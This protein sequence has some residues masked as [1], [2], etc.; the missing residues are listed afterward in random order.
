LAIL[1]T[2]TLGLVWSRG[3]K[4]AFWGGFATAGWAY[5]AA[6]FGPWLNMNGGP[7]LLTTAILDIVYTTVAGT[8]L[9][10]NGTPGAADTLYATLTG[11]TPS[12]NGTPGAAYGLGA[13]FGATPAP[14]PAPHS[15]WTWW[16]SVS[17]GS[18]FFGP[19]RMYFPETYFY[20]GHFL[21][22]LLVGYLGARVARSFFDSRS[23]P[24]AQPPAA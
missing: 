1:S 5:L 22:A 4:Q 12:A 2:A 3:R 6:C 9:S 13:G 15:S 19:N 21:F 16:T 10:A 14:P 11:A 8:K 20:T 17:K 24:S 7:F 18:F 23:A